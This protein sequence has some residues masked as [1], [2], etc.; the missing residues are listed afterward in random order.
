MRTKE[1]ET[2]ESSLRGLKGRGNLLLFALKELSILLA[3]AK[4]RHDG[5]AIAYSASRPLYFLA[6]A[7][8]SVKDEFVSCHSALD[9]ESRSSE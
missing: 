3:K 6:G 9:A 8:Y 5:V 1:N 2:K 7:Y 4:S